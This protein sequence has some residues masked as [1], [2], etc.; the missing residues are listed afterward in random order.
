MGKKGAAEQRGGP[1][2]A[3]G[4]SGEEDKSGEIERDEA[5]GGMRMG[6]QGKWG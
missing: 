3:K 4:R 1:S 2:G 5:G 6:R